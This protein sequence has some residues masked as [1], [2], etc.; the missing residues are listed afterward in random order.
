MKENYMR[1][2]VF[3]AIGVIWGGAILASALFRS[4]PQGS[5]AY[6]SGQIAGLVFGVLMFIAGIYYLLKDGRKKS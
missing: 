2:R 4:G 5:G 1:N 6:A 3:G